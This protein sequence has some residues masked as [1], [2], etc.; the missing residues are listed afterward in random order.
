MATTSILAAPGDFLPILFVLIAIASGIINFVKER[1]AAA[2][3]ANFD[4]PNLAAKGK[5]NPELQSEIDAFLQEVSPNDFE[6]V[7]P[8][9]QRN[10]EQQRRRRRKN[11]DE[12]A[13]R[14]R[15]VRARREHEK[16]QAKADRKRESVRKRHLETSELSEVSS[17]HE[18]ANRHVDSSVQN[19]HLEPQI[20]AAAA[21]LT[22][23]NAT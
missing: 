13:E 11:S 9:R 20:H 1:R 12:D 15:Q 2:N 6:E 14:R 5:V 23:L 10:A 7:A 21:S 19:R 16:R 8:V 3:K 17:R 22:E 4:S 18:V